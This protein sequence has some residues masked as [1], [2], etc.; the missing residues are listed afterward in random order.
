MGKPSFCLVLSVVAAIGLGV[1]SSALV[2]AEATGPFPLVVVVDDR[3]Q[4]LPRVL[5]QAEKEAARIYWQAGVRAE[6]LTP[7]ALTRAIG[8]DEN[9]PP[10]RPAFHRSVDRPAPSPSDAHHFEV[11]DGGR[12]SHRRRVRGSGVRVL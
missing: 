2:A 8:D 9:L 7:S 6:W 11:P 10:V 1:D 12:T 5:D 4:I 3:A